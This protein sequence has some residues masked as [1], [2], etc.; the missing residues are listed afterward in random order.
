VSEFAHPGSEPTEFEPVVLHD[1]EGSYVTVVVRNHRVVQVGD[2]EGRPVLVREFL[3]DEGFRALTDGVLQALGALG[4]LSLCFVGDGFD[5]SS[6]HSPADEEALERSEAWAAV[7]F[8]PPGGLAAF[9][10]AVAGVLDEHQ[11]PTAWVIP[12]DNDADIVVRTRN[13]GWEPQGD[14]VAPDSPAGTGFTSG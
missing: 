10:Q 5:P 14:E 12:S 8:V 1:A 6:V 3:D 9:R 7:F 11:M 4:G 2:T 13:H